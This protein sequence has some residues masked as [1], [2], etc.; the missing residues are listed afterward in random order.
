MFFSF[1]DLLHVDPW[2]LLKCEKLIVSFQ[3]LNGS[4]IEQFSLIDRF[5]HRVLTTDAHQR[6]AVISLCKRTQCFEN[7][8]DDIGRAQCLSGFM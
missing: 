8:V 6:P 2:G 3:T 7:C 4:L 5:S 1:V